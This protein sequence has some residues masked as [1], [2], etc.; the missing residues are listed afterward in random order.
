MIFDYYCSRTTTGRAH[1]LGSPRR[2]G[3]RLNGA[4]SCL[5]REPQAAHA[6]RDSRTRRPLLE[7][8]GRRRGWAALPALPGPEAA[9]CLRISTDYRV[10][11]ERTSRVEGARSRIRHETGLACTP[12]PARG[13]T[14]SLTQMSP[15]ATRRTPLSLRPRNRDDRRKPRRSD[16]DPAVSGEDRLTR[17]VGE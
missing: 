10:V 8:L 13:S 12:G 17:A 5:C 6:H 11:G 9:R 14:S 7:D 1:L 3:R 2:S 15:S 16:V 4:P